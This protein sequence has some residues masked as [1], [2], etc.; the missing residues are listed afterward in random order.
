MSSDEAASEE[1]ASAGVVLAAGVGVSPGEGIGE[2]HVDVDDALDAIDA[3]RPVVIALESAAPGDVVVMARAAGVM[4]IIGDRESHVAVVTR[5]AAVPAVVGLEELTIS[6]R[7]IRI[8]GEAV[9]VGE[10]VVVDGTRGE[11]R[12]TRPEVP[13]GSAASM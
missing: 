9:A 8:S 2:L 13:R 10:T 11:I 1:A 5:G 3:G 4:T 7:G 12:R 6:E